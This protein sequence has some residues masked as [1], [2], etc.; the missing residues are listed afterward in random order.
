MVLD[1][2]GLDVLGMVEFGYSGLLYMSRGHGISL[3][4]LGSPLEYF[5]T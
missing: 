3:V 1:R 4:N 5:S 2:V